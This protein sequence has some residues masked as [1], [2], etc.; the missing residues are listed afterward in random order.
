MIKKILSLGVL[1]IVLTGCSEDNRS[2]KEK[3][4]EQ[5]ETP[6]KMM[7][8]FLAETMNIPATNALT[9]CMLDT[10]VNSLS[11]EEARLMVDSTIT[12][13]FEKGAEMMAIQQKFESQEINTRIMMKC[14]NE[15]ENVAKSRRK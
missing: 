5:L 14:Y 11:D 3:L 2:P 6:L 15:L 10:M 9:D 4:R 1:A 13:R 8:P 7:I 12:E